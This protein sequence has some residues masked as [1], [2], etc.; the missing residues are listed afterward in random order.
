MYI[1]YKL[2]IIC[3]IWYIYIILYL[4]V[5]TRLRILVLHRCASK[6]LSAMPHTPSH[7]TRI[8][9]LSCP[10]RRPDTNTGPWG[11]QRGDNVEAML[12]QRAPVICAPYFSRMVLYIL[13]SQHCPSDPRYVRYILI[14]FEMFEILTICSVCIDAPWFSMIF[15]CL[16]CTRSESSHLSVVPGCAMRPWAPGPQGLARG[17]AASWSPQPPLETRGKSSYTAIILPNC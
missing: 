1:I 16:L 9:P 3:I 8:R 17:P 2:Y 6:S 7:V 15:R 14:F 12:T 10:D 13:V 4:C 11:R 5:C